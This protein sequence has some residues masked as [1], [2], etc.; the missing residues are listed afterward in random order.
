[1]YY[2]P[3]YVLERDI[4]CYNVNLQSIIHQNE[5]QLGEKEIIEEYRTIKKVELKK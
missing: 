4:D 1:M 5:I 3:G 2:I